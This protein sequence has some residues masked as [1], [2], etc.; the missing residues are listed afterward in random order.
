MSQYLELVADRPLTLPPQPASPHVPPGGV[1][2]RR[3][4]R[5]DDANPELIALMR[6][7]SHAARLRV[8]MYDAPGF[9]L[10]QQHKRPPVTGRGVLHMMVAMT[11][12][13]GACAAAFKTMLV[14]W[15]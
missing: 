6:K 4:G 5:M 10:P 15:G 14:L 11:A 7:P 8:A 1:E 12:C 13:S 9:L 3:P 2:R